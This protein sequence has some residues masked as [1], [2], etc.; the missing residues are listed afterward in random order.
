M[1]WLCMMVPLLQQHNVNLWRMVVW[2]VCYDANTKARLNDCKMHH[3]GEDGLYAVDHAVVDLHGTKT[4][5]HSNKRCGIVASIVP[6]STFICLPNT[7]HPM[8]MLKRI[9]FKRWWFHRQHQRRRYIHTLNKICFF[10]SCFL[11]MRPNVHVVLHS[12]K[13]ES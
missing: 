6:K 9:E 13:S 2:G 10:Y 5:I 11:S 12:S 7:I 8:T 4:D 3:N 1:G